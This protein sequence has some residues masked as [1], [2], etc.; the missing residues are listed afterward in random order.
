MVASSDTGVTPEVVFASDV[1]EN[2]QKI[3]SNTT[4]QDV[5]G[6]KISLRKECVASLFSNDL[7]FSIISAPV[8]VRE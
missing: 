5:F 6:T 2:T 7:L 1:E 3:S 8:Q 4:Y